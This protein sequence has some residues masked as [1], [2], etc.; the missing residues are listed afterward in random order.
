MKK[1]LCILLVLA[2]AVCAVPAFAATVVLSPQNL[3][4]DGQA[5][6][7]DKYNIDGSNYFKLRD[8]AKLLSGTASQFEVG[9]Q[10]GV[11]SITT[12]LPYSPNGSELMVGQDN[13]ATAVPSAQTIQINGQTRSDLT[14]YNIGG[15]NFFKLR[16]LG[17]ALGF[18]VDY[19]AQSNTA[20]V[21]SGGAA[22]ATPAPQPAQTGPLSLTALYTGGGNDGPW[23]MEEPGESAPAV[24]DVDGDG[25]SEI[26][27]MIRRVFCLD[28][29]TGTVKWAAPTGHAVSEGADQSQYFGAPNLPTPVKLVDYD[30]NGSL[31]IVTVATNYGL[32]QSFIA[33]YNGQGEF[34]RQWKTAAPVRA[35]TV[36][37]FDGDGK[38]EI[39]AGL[40]VGP[41]G[42]PSVY[43][44]NNDG[45]VHAGWPV[46][47]GYGLYSDT[48]CAVDLD[49]DGR[50]ELVFLF[51][52]DSVEAYSLDGKRVNAAG[53][54]YA[55]Y[56]WG[57]FPVCEDYAHELEYVEAVKQSGAKAFAF[58]PDL[59]GR[60]RAGRF[61][62]TGTFG[63][64]TAADM[65]GDGSEELV[66]TGMVADGALAMSEGM[67]ESYS[68]V[69]QYFTTFILNRDRTR[70][71]NAAKG[72]DW[73]QMPT[74]TGKY[75]TLAEDYGA[76]AKIGK[77]DLMPVV[78][79]LDGDGNKEILF[80]NY[81]GCIHCF[82]LDK[83]EKGSWPYRVDQNVLS[84]ATRPV[85]ADLDGDGR[86]EVIF[87]TFVDQTQTSVRGEVIVLDCTGSVR[88]RITV[89]SMWGLNGA[90]DTLYANCVIGMPAVADVDGDGQ[91]GIVVNTKNSG[92]CVYKVR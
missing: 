78:A 46:V 21:L 28:A 8:I 22:A 6:H 18:D 34:L 57:Y 72:F 13:S 38:C 35:M 66:F 36:A 1:A 43:L 16:D 60:D 30:G 49:G 29:A 69:C 47:A 14:V 12:G 7:C 82:S 11:V 9:F 56:P 92:V 62:V 74:D 87:G 41:G 79:D 54:P 63:G 88:A 80:S 90:E 52:E 53:A 17:D 44:Y 59:K 4:V 91:P 48:M 33:V 10:N 84:F 23:V 5:V 37:D 65:D 25:R 24:G 67:T 2:M 58:S 83:E 81:D 61:Y 50:K 64:V 70:F 51:D 89:P 76:N 71:Q 20:I 3:T 15:N 39:A 40:G 55:G 75:L 31:D 26:V 68:G 73:T 32:N 27:F 85:A 42:K 77:P 45:S 19:D 86:M